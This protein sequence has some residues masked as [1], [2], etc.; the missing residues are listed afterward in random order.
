[1]SGGF[2]GVSGVRTGFGIAFGAM[3][4]AGISFIGLTFLDGQVPTGTAVLAS[5]YGGQ[6]EAAP[7][8]PAPEVI[9]YNQVVHKT[10]WYKTA[11]VQQNR[12][13]AASVGQ[14]AARVAKVDSLIPDL[15]SAMIRAPRGA[16]VPVRFA[17]A[18]SWA[19]IS[20]LARAKPN[21][22]QR[23]VIR[24]AA[25]YASTTGFSEFKRAK[26]EKRRAAAERCLAQAI[27]FEA[28][29]EPTLGQ[30]AVANIVLNRVRSPYYPDSVC[31]VV[32]QNKHR[33]MSCQFTFAC[34][35]RSDQAR[36][37][38]S[39]NG[40]R[41]LARQM[42]KGRKRLS[43]MTNAT[44]YHANYVSPKWSRKFRTVKRIG[45]HIFYRNNKQH[46]PGI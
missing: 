21:Y 44:F 41:K 36:D 19:P 37:M 3:F 46:T 13:A 17:R 40:A 10:H 28:R 20:F 25:L 32:F 8:A 38:S 14:Q 31:G 30:I 26:I 29:G 34:D 15:D 11:P 18:D 23:V 7:S 42:L 45:R 2:F 27:Y 16:G 1:M 39:W 43:S 9:H 12:P 24:P 22:S 5:I 6:A 35:G 33:H 4:C